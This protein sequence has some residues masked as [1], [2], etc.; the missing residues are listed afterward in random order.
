M[1]GVCNPDIVGVQ[2]HLQI[3]DGHSSRASSISKLQVGSRAIRCPYQVYNK[4]EIMQ[5]QKRQFTSTAR[6]NTT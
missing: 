1:E 3:E 4:K 6:E 5:W 2:A